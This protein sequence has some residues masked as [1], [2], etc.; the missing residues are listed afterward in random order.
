MVEQAP[1]PKFIDYPSIF[2]R[3]SIRNQTAFA[4]LG[5]PPKSV[6]QTAQAY[7]GGRLPLTEL[8]GRLD[9]SGL[10]EMPPKQKMVF[11][12]ISDLNLRE[13]TA[14]EIAY[15][16]GIG[17]GAFSALTRKLYRR[18]GVSGRSEAAVLRA[19]SEFRL[20]RARSKQS[21]DKTA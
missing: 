6:I 10:K 21:I 16:L 4:E 18:L 12:A 15:S 14:S 8:R 1:K 7:Y 2:A 13:M 9:F 5:R 11:N 3:R 20:P 17:Q 19:A